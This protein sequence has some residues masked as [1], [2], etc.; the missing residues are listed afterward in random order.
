MSNALLS[1]AVPV[2]ITRPEPQ[3]SR[4]AAALAAS[5]LPVRPVVSPLMQ[6]RFLSPPL[7]PGPHAGVILTSEAGAEAA[8][9]L[10]SAGLDLPGTSHC[11][12][13]TTADAARAAGF[14]VATLAPTAEDLTPLLLTVPGPLLYL[15]GREVS[16]PLDVVLTK[17]GQPTQAATVYEQNAMPLSEQALTLLK[18]ADPL[19]LPVF[20][21]R[22]ARLFANACPGPVTARIWPVCISA[23]AAAALPPALVKRAVVAASPDGAA[24][25]SAIGRVVMTL[26]P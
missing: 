11:V 7:P 21:A 1:D 20:S 19:I 4:L 26:S 18:S 13:A 9:R 22:S 17:A 12:G 3:A 23:K 5:G 10:K 15:H 14:L 8:G 24:L 2:L 6:T 16:V 25:I